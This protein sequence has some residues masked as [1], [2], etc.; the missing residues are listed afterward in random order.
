VE[1]FSSEPFALTTQEDVIEL[2]INK[3]FSA[4]VTELFIN[5]VLNN[6]QCLVVQVVQGDEK[7]AVVLGSCNISLLPFFHDDLCFEQWY[8]IVSNVNNENTIQL[9]VKCSASDHLLTREEKSKAHYLSIVMNGIYNLPQNWIP[10]SSDVNDRKY[11]VF[12]YW[13]MQLMI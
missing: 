2:G 12:Y 13:T 10:K 9:F 8:P 7:N 3:Q 4:T 5:N 1:S 11:C 6:E